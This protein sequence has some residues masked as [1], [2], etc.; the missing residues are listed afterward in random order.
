MKFEMGKEGR[1]G[2]E[3]SLYWS[4]KGQTCSHYPLACLAEQC[5][6]SRTNYYPPPPPSVPAPPPSEAALPSLT[7]L[8]MEIGEGGGD[9][10][11]R[12]EARANRTPSLLSRTNY[13]P[14][15]PPP[16]RSSP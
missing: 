7:Y 4:K 16:Q 14:S 5:L 11:G 6:L 10:G 15:T 1:Q 2:S 3:A 8:H 9:G 13:Y 12:E